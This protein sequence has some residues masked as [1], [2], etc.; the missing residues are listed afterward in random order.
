MKNVLK[1]AIILLLGMVYLVASDRQFYF[2]GKYGRLGSIS[3]DAKDKKGVYLRWDVIEGNMPSDI[4]TIS[5]IRTYNDTNTTLLS[6]IP[7]NTPMQASNI[8]EIFNQEGSQRRLFEAINFISNNDDASC[9]GAN[10][11]NIGEKVRTC[12]ENNY[13]AFLA[14]RANFDV[15]RARYRAYLDLNVTQDMQ[16]V[17]YT[18]LGFNDDGSKSIILG[19]IEVILKE[20]QIFPAQNF[21]QIQESKCNDGKYALDDYRVALKWRNGGE[22]TDFFANNLMISGYDIYYSTKRVDELPSD[23]IN[24]DIAALAANKPHNA[25]GNVDLSQYHLKKANDTLITLGGQ[26][27]KDGK[28]IYIESQKVLKKRGFKPGEKRYYFLVPRDFT[29]NYGPTSVLVVEIP[30]KLPPAMPVNPRAVEDGSSFA[31]MWENLKLKNYAEHYKDV[32]KVCSTTVDSNKRVQFVEIDKSCKEGKGIIVNFN[33]AK[34]Y[35]YRFDNIQDAASFS[36]S[37]LDGFS[38]H[39]ESEKGVCDVNIHPT[40][41]SLNHLVAVVPKSNDDVIKFVDNSVQKSKVYWYRIMSVTEHNISS[42]LTAPIRAFMPKRDLLPAPNFTVTSGTVFK[43]KYEENSYFV[44][45]N[46]TSENVDKVEVVIDNKTFTLDKIGNSFAATKELHNQLVSFDEKVAIFFYSGN[47]ML[48]SF[49]FKVNKVFNLRDADS[50]SKYKITGEHH[51][52]KLY[53]IKRETINGGYSFGSCI[54]IKY[55][56]NYFQQLLARKGCIET[57]VRIGLN[58]YTKSIECSPK[59][60]FELCNNQ[61]KRGDLVSYRVIECLADGRCSQPTYFDY[62]QLNDNS[63]PNVPNLIGFDVSKDDSIASVSFIPQLE[64]VKGTMLYLYKQDSNETYSKIVAHIGNK[65]LKPINDSFENLTVNYGDTWCV[66]AK[67]VGLNGKVSEWSAPLCKDIVEEDSIP[68]KMLAWPKIPN[69]V[70]NDQNFTATFDQST[71][72]TKIF[73]AH[74][75]ISKENRCSALS[76]INKATNFVVYRQ[77]IHDDGSKSKFVQVSPLIEGAT[78]KNDQFYMSRNM[79]IDTQTD[80]NANVYFIDKYPY[81]LGEKYKYLILF[82]DRDSKEISSYSFTNPS[83]VETR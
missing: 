17:E 81:I 58:R 32:L 40:D 72:I 80:G 66:K 22:K 35:V 69:N 42:P 15:A 9:I 47:K 18:L 76:M 23:F 78:C 46:N 10:I 21:K 64:K 65:D 63:I 54:N 45:E 56:D 41:N 34:Y 57:S 82:F 79:G 75:Y 62:I 36:D 6:N 37:D 33:I 67:T 77:T 1:I 59:K 25:K 48:K 26:A 27:G 29:G 16:S 31:V 24:T 49:S 71:K 39:D 61:V 11:T 30:D 68:P 8:K 13:W 51:L 55:D 74:G 3:S 60:E 38:D 14:S 44:A 83:V 43:V 7:A 70:T 53:S 20:T 2:I 4:K 5:L 28:P 19:K 50:P 73:L 12:L 52:I